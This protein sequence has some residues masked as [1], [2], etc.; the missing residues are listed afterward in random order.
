M[1]S[2]R[3]SALVSH[4]DGMFTRFSASTNRSNSDLQWD[5]I[6][7]LS[8][9]QKCSVDFLPITWQPTL[10][11]LGEGG[12]GTISQ[13]A[14][15]ADMPLAFKRFHEG[16]D[17]GS[18]DSGMDFLPLI[19]EVL[20]LS[21]RPIQE[22]PN[23]VTLKG[24]CWEIKP[25]TERAVPVLVFKKASWDLQQFMNVSEGK[26]MS[27]DDRLEICADIGNAIM[28]LHAYGLSYQAISDD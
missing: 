18:G 6:A 2:A 15:A 3:N 9:V 21:Q 24:V 12:S 16:G 27:I 19:S 20:I 17:S 7:F 28:T 13:S 5:L 8:V 22:H 11:I 4:S 25:L 23:I 10:G 14:F 26:N 1:F